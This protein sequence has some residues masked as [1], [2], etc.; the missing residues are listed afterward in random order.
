MENI[1]DRVFLEAEWLYLISSAI[2]GSSSGWAAL[3]R[4]LASLNQKQQL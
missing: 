1:K 2:L 3:W 4:S